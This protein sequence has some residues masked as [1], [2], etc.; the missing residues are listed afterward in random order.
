VVLCPPAG[1]LDAVPD[2]CLPPRCTGAGGPGAA[3]RF[4]PRARRDH[5]VADVLVRGPQRRELRLRVHVDDHHGDHRRVHELAHLRGLR[6]LRACGGDDDQRRLV[7]LRAGR[8]LVDVPDELGRLPQ[9]PHL[10]V[11]EPEHQRERLVRDRRRRSVHHLVRARHQLGAGHGDVLE[12]A[13]WDG[14][15]VRRLVAGGEGHDDA[16]PGRRWRRLRRRQRDDVRPTPPTATIQT[17]LST[18]ARPRPATAPTTTATARSTRASGAPGTAT[19]TATPTA[20]RRA[21]RSRARRPPGTSRTAPTATT[22]TRPSTPAPPST[23]TASTTTA[24]R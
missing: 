23:A 4:R 17:P 10:L 15:P 5:P 22:P 8:H 6:H 14:Q 12:L 7:A 24:T 11:D 2:P 16:V 19:R 13:R 1:A 3:P 9:R 21:S 18:P 20:T